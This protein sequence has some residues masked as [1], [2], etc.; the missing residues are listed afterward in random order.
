MTFAATGCYADGTALPVPGDP[1]KS[2]A[3]ATYLSIVADVEAV[4]LEGEALVDA[5]GDLDAPFD[6]SVGGASAQL[7]DTKEALFRLVPV[8]GLIAT[9][10]F[11]VLFLMFG[12]L[13]SRPRRSS[14][15]CSA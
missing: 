6:V 2:T 8:A 12:S 14:S 15:T 11:V 5:I 10:T 13:W 1:A 4:S 9:V 3:D 7:S